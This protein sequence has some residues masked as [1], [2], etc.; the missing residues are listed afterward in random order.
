MDL[1]AVFR[2]TLRRR[3]F[4]GVLLPG[5]AR[6]ARLRPRAPLPG[7]ERFSAPTRDGAA[8]MFG[9]A[10]ESFGGA[11]ESFGGAARD[12]AARDRTPE[13]ARGDPAII[14][15]VGGGG[16]KGGAALNPLPPLPPLPLLPL[17]P[18]L[19]LLLLLLPPP[20]RSAVCLGHAPP[21]PHL[22]PRR[23]SS[24]RVCRSLSFQR[25]LSEQKNQRAIP[26]NT[27]LEPEIQ[28]QKHGRTYLTLR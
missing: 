19:P 28:Q 2:R 16:G 14:V 18:P 21:R 9:G 24:P 3:R 10:G 13:L 12:G 26:K 20:P 25:S 5:K 11:G 1:T 7:P 27:P 23:L 22:M 6:L 15:C 8:E 4:S 17:L